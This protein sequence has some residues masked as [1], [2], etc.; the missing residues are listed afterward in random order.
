MKLSELK[1]SALDA[2]AGA[3]TP[4]QIIEWATGGRFRESSAYVLTV[5]HRG[6]TFHLGKWSGWEGSFW[7]VEARTGLVFL[8]HLAYLKL[9]IRQR[10]A[11]RFMADGEG[12][13]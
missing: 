4:A 9:T 13:E 1:A 5:S 7:M 6:H 10:T 11:T 8:G 12:S 2:L 3:H